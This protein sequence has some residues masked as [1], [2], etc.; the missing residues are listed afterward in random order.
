MR[1]VGLARTIYAENEYEIDII[2]L[3][4][5]SQWILDLRN[6]YKSIIAKTFECH[7]QCSI[8]FVC[9]TKALAHYLCK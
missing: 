5:S 4:V 1:I 3:A 7:L 9:E 8:I 6:L 2:S